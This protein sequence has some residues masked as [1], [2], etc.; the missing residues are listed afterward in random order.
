MDPSPQRCLPRSRQQD[1][2]RSRRD[3]DSWTSS[4]YVRSLRSLLFRATRLAD[5]SSFPFILV[6]RSMGSYLP[7]A[8]LVATSSIVGNLTA[9]AVMNGKGEPEARIPGGQAPVAGV[10]TVRSSFFPLLPPSFTF[11][12]TPPLTT[13]QFSLL[14]LPVPRSE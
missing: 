4:S 12:G 8:A 11:A 1:Y 6:K 5:L 7:F 2:H 9:A 14:L 10:V 3:A 13:F